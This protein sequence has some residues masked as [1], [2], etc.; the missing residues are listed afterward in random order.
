MCTIRVIILQ[1]AC[2]LDMFRLII[3]FGATLGMNSKS[4]FKFFA[5]EEG[6]GSQTKKKARK[7]LCVLA[8]GAKDNFRDRLRLCP[9]GFDLLS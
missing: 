4:R 7:L 8:D 9:S 6:I 2:D 5:K 3:G 1:T